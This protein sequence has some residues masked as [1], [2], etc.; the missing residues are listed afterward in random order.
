MGERTRRGNDAGLKR[1]EFP[2]KHNL[3]FN[4]QLRELDQD[5]PFAMLVLEADETLQK[6]NEMTPEQRARNLPDIE[7][8]AT[9]LAMAVR[10]C[11]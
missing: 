11:R 6:V 1:V 7:E 2:V 8:A 5:G 4:M 9:L 3:E 10:I